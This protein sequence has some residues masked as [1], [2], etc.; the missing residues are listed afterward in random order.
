MASAD[1]TLLDLYNSS[2]DTQPH[3]IIVKQLL[4]LFY[5]LC[6]IILGEGA[7][8]FCVLGNT[9]YKPFREL[10]R[11]LFFSGLICMHIYITFMYTR[12]SE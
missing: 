11:P 5:F 8:I 9:S 10:F 7:S 3:P 1:N 4:L 12:F 6:I 2:D